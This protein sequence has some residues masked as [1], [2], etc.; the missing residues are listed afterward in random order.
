[1]DDL[2]S[3]AENFQL[4]KKKLITILNDM[5]SRTLN[6]AKRIFL[7]ETLRNPDFFKIKTNKNIII[8]ISHVFA[9]FPI[10]NSLSN[11]EAKTPSPIAQW[12]NHEP[13]DTILKDYCLSDDDDASK[14]NHFFI[15][16][17]G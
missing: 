10:S 4:V 15:S 1:M 13:K 12:R 2:K 17:Y 7:L 11:Y 9:L 14:P 8:I 16:L 3:L 6:C 5:V